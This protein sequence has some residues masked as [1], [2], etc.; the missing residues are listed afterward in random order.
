MSP[1]GWARRLGLIWLALWFGAAAVAALRGEA[2]YALA[3]GLAPPEPSHPLGFDAYGRDAL[4]TLLHASLRSGALALAATVLTFGM[5]MIAG[6]A[7]TMAPALA[8]AAGRRALELLLAFPT[9]LLALA[10]AA[11]RGPGWETLIVALCLGTVPSLTRL[12]QARGRELLAAEHVL[13]ALALGAD[14]TG[15]ARRHLLGPLLALAAVKLPGLF[16][17]C[18]MAEATLT[19]LGLGA[20]LGHETW[21]SLLAQAKEYLLEAPHLALATG[22]PLV[23][24]VLSLQLVAERATE[25]PFRR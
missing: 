15:I 11:V 3:R 4:A 7:L 8:R 24:T 1:A 23:L 5:G 18:L 25:S 16:A 21:G 12:V 19:Y 13:A 14:A 22:V 6:I 17:H 9:L 20:P 2:G 10:W